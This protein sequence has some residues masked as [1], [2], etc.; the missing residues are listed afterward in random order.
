MH[1]GIKAFMIKFS[2]KYS[3]SL[4]LSKSKEKQQAPSTCNR[5]M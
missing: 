5:L 1:W 2:V 4:I 3:L